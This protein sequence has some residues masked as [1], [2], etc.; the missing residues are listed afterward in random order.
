MEKS[1]VYDNEL[2][3]SLL[4]AVSLLTAASYFLTLRT[5]LTKFKQKDSFFGKNNIFHVFSSKNKQSPRWH[6]FRPCRALTKSKCSWQTKYSFNE[7]HNLK[8]R[9]LPVMKQKD[10]PNNDAPTKT[11]SATLNVTKLD[12]NLSSLINLEHSPQLFLV[13]YDKSIFCAWGPHQVFIENVWFL[14]IFCLYRMI[15]KTCWSRISHLFS[16]SVG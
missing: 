3:L 11:R 5:I 2:H 16:K 15:E 9:H 1:A 8:R 7:I 6:F 12:F 10:D 4:G 14:S 13:L